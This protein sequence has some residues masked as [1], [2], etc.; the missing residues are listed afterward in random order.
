[1]AIDDHVVVAE[2][3][4][5]GELPGEVGLLATAGPAVPARTAGP[6]PFGQSAPAPPAPLLHR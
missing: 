5:G 6:R 4:G 1:M 3:V 2:A